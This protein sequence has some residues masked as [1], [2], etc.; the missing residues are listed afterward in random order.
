MNLLR[1]PIFLLVASLLL[2]WGV[3]AGSQPPV[4]LRAGAPETVFSAVRAEVLLRE[5]YP[6]NEPHVSGSPQNAAMRDRIVALLE[7]FGYEVEIQKTFHCKA[8]FGH[9][10]PVENILAVRKGARDNGA[11]LLTAHY[12]SAWAGPG[13]ADDGAGVAAVL[14]IAR[15]ATT[16]PE[17]S[18]DVIFLI[19][20]GEEQG[21]IGADAF[22][23]QHALFPTVRAVINLEARGSSGASTMFETGDKNR[24][25]IRMLA[26]NLDHP[27]ANSLAYEVYRRM[28]NDTDFS[29]YR[30]Y[31]LPGVNFAFTG[32]A[33]IYH[34]RIDDLNHLDFGSLQ[35]H[36][37]NAW[38]MLLALDE[39]S[40]ERLSSSEDAAY[41]DL[42]GLL[43]LHYPVSSA[44]GLALV[45]SV[46]VLVA[47]RRAFYRQVVFQQVL[48]TVFGVLLMAI[49]L[50]LSGWLLSWP[51]GRW[52][53]LN[54]LEHP[55]PWL[56]R[57]V[58][59]LAAMWVIS[60]ILKFLSTRSSTG[61]VMAATWCVF[62]LLALALAYML[63]IAGYLA[64][65]PLL[66]FVLGLFM[67]GFR[68]KEQPRLLFA[69]LGGFLAALYLGLYF[70][71]QL[72]V[73][74]NFDQSQ[75]KVAPL[76]LPALAS[77]PLLAWYYE[78]KAGKNRLGVAWLL[79]VVAGCVGQ[80]FVPAYARETPRDMNLMVR[81]DVGRESALL[82][83]ESGLGQPDLVFARNHGFTTF[84]LPVFD[85]E[86]R[87]VLAQ[88]VTPPALPELV[89]LG[90]TKVDAEDTGDQP[91][92]VLD[93]DLPPE[94]RL[95]A[96]NFPQKSGLSRATV[97]GQLAFDSSLDSGRA[98]QGSRVVI[99]HPLPGKTRFEFEFTGTGPV[100]VLVTA[101]YDMPVELLQ[102]YADDWPA[103]AQPAFLGERALKT[104]VIKLGE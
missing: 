58:L 88:E 16:Q 91:R 103:D 14:E 94:V 20:D 24:G 57:S 84:K 61:S 101:R 39:R 100:D 26:K 35:H 87:E 53:D 78:G 51:L 64:V 28:P 2:G 7:R 44:M 80:Q 19:T 34:S 54:P 9:C 102:A 40:L 3:Y 50:P 46:L 45:L 82:V 89:V 65:L 62:S 90:N 10:S 83:L 42:F 27:V 97:A 79:L 43:L 47:I 95:L 72:D 60:R 25:M 67:D 59:F 81:Q 68:W 86:E 33:S 92:Y 66:G 104:S 48:W 77:L 71:F 32:K 31:G 5:L 21:L 22:A 41:I 37:E 85:G 52:V 11:I 15:L 75:F 36:G 4:P 30:A 8:E 69:S 74:L 76:W 55:Y 49:A 6:D 18:N 12:D 70:F 63:P 1:E 13:V 38:G 17:F 73:V 98:R 99:N 56:G 29:V 96:F 93:L 23:T